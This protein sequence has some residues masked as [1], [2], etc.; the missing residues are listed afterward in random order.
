MCPFS[1]FPVCA[2]LKTRLRI[3]LYAVGMDE[4]YVELMEERDPPEDEEWTP[5]PHEKR[6]W[7]RRGRYLDSRSFYAMFYCM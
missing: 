6:Y 4:D 3:V 5:V 7:A 1:L 2:R